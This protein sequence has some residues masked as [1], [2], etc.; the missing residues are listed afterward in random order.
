MRIGQNPIK[1]VEK[2]AP[3]AP[4]TVVVIV[5]IPFLRGYYQNSLEILKLCLASIKANTS[6]EFDLLVFDN[7][8]CAEVREFLGQEQT[9]GNIQFL[10]HSSRNIGKPA[11]WNIALASAPG[12]YITYADADVY[13]YPGWLET[14]LDALAEF[15]QAGMVTAMPMLVP[16]KY[17]T[18]TLKWAKKQ[19][20][21]KVHRGPLLPWDDF[22]RHAR[23]LGDS[24]KQARLFYDSNEAIKLIKRK[25]EYYVGA[26]HF[27]FTAGKQALQEVLPIAADR[28]MGRVRLLDEAMNARGYLRLC[29]DAWFVQHLGN[30][31]P[32]QTDFAKP[33]NSL[34]NIPR[35]RRRS[36]FWRL[37]PVR[38]A[39]QVLYGWS[40]ARLH[41]TD[42]EK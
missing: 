29:T 4:V 20:G 41:Q 18:A 39:L 33:P 35:G 5:F 40:F 1:S 11:A 24:E 15:P 31:I 32:R 12:E 36:G 21:V 38:K 14:S 17:S 13:F 16:E 10:M 2:I 25:K 27:Q 6:G 3:P 42:Q 9:R 26:A 7:G 37:P 34:P 28:P 30:A 8:S 23:S 19:S 22:W